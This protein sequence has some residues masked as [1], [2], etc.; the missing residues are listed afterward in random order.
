LQQA[1]F[2]DVEVLGLHHGDRLL[3]WEADHG[4]LVA[5]HVG[6]ALSGDWPDDLLELLPQLTPDDFRVGEPADAHDLIG[7]A[8]R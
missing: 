8:R 7:L 2:A 6:A 1:G 3:A 5:A 4:S